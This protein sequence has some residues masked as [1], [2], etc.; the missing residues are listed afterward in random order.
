MT[1]PITHINDFDPSLIVFGE[2][3]ENTPFD[4][5]IKI[6]Y[7]EANELS[8]LLLVIDDL[9]VQYRISCYTNSMGKDEYTIKLSLDDKKCE[10]FKALNTLV[11]DAC[12]KNNWIDIK[13][14]DR[15][16]PFI[17]KHENEQ[18]I[19][20]PIS[21]FDGQ[22]ITEFYDMENNPIE[23]DVSTLKDVVSSGCTGKC[24]IRLSSIKI[25]YDGYSKINT[26]LEQFKI[27][28]RPQP[29]LKKCL[30]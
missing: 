27:T 18:I 6:T 11:I 10:V 8:P 21:I 5:L 9:I 22:V 12:I 3:K 23:V 13:H 25:T 14:R 26:E 7:N 20:L 29:K 28:G 4:K 16:Y 24:L 15:L 2:P 1:T 17:C 30:L 19:T